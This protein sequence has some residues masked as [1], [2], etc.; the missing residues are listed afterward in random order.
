MERL[1]VVEGRAADATATL[2][3]QALARIEPGTEIVLVSTRPVDLTDSTRFGHLWSDPAR[4]QAVRQVRVVD[5]SGEELGRY[6]QP[7]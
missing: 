1:A 6:F 7:E 3:E 5:T 4:R 2:I